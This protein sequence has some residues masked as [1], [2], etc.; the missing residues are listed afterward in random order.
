METAPRPA[1][2]MLH[3]WPSFNFLFAFK[4][5][6]IKLKWYTY[7]LTWWHKRGKRESIWWNCSHFIFAF[8]A[9]SIVRSY[10]CVYMHTLLSFCGWIIARCDLI[11]CLFK[12]IITTNMELILIFSYLSISSC[13]RRKRICIMYN[14]ISFKCRQFFQFLS[15]LFSLFLLLLFFYVLLSTSCGTWM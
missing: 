9:H 13:W 6:I 14:W 12:M 11:Y 15:F 1:T 4:F 10:A 5:V 2:Q 3:I 8:L 7:I